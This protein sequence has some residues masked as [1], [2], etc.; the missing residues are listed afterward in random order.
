[1][2]DLTTTTLASNKFRN[3]VNL[4]SL[5]DKQKESKDY[6]RLFMAIKINQ[7]TAIDKSKIQKAYR[8]RYG[9]RDVAEFDHITAKY[10]HDFP[11]SLTHTPLID[12]HAK[13]LEGQITSAPLEYNI[14]ARDVKSLLDINTEKANHII[15]DYENEIVKI[16]QEN[17]R[18]INAGRQDA[19]K[20]EL[21]QKVLD[22]VLSKYNKNWKSELEIQ[23]KLVLDAEIDSLSVKHELTK[24]FTDF[25]TCGH[26]Y[27][28]DKVKNDGTRIFERINP[29][30]I[31]Y[32]KGQNQTFI[33]Q[34]DCVV[35]KRW[36]LITDAILKYGNRMKAD[37]IEHLYKLHNHSSFN[38]TNT[39]VQFSTTGYLSHY[40]TF[41]E[42]DQGNQNTNGL[43]RFILVQDVEWKSPNKV[44]NKFRQDR[45]SGTRIGR[46]IYV[47]CEKDKYVQRSQDDPGYCLLSYEGILF[48]EHNNEARSMFLDTKDLGD[49]YDI[50]NFYLQNAIALSGNKVITVP[51]N[52]IPTEFGNNQTE[53]IIEHQRYLRMGFNYINPSQEG[54]RFDNYGQAIDLSLGNGIK[55]IVDILAVIEERASL[56]TGVNRQAIGQISQTDGKGTTETA[57]NQTGLV[58]QKLFGTHYFF[59]R[60]VLTSVMNNA[61][62]SYKLK[63]TSKYV[64]GVGKDIFTLTDKFFNADYDVFI[65]DGNE[66]QKQ[67]EDF[68]QYALKLVD[69]KMLNAID[70][71]NIYSSK[72]LSEI[73]EHL[74]EGVKKE[75]QSLLA[76]LQNKLAQLEQ[77]NKKLQA[78]F[79]KLNADD[80]SINKSKVEIEKAKYEREAELK[81]QELRLKENFDKQK[82]ELDRKRVELEQLQIQFS[83]ASV[84]VKNS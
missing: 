35:R 2:D 39:Y 79:D 34:C 62:I 73:K 1:M 8:I 16:L 49:D 22:D 3:I 76:D 15:R 72:S 80:I 64:L 32:I 77:E 65:S 47:D 54:A 21:G 58:T 69:Q 18:H 51:T 74:L 81:E 42:F 7:A 43:S 40:D 50:Y 20:N 38:Y 70:G 12:R 17:D 25:A 24:A 14:T 41:N 63:K 27:I 11:A 23:S 45:Y 57:I 56:I 55:L 59:L 66:E 9:I 30:E 10:G 6:F 29:N 68:K 13:V 36:M 67:I 83:N 71:I 53:R 28:Q 46:D 33:S 60:K 52:A 5:T 75:E 26:E 31:F 4:D 82:I 37:E 48:D 19:I 78:A 61:K 84:E 44:K